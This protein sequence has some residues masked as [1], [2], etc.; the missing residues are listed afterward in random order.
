MFSE[1]GVKVALT[2]YVVARPAASIEY[3]YVVKKQG[4]LPER[5]QISAT[6]PETRIALLK[7]APLVTKKKTPTKTKKKKP[8]KTEKK[9]K[10]T[11]IFAR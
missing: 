11:P 2:P 4:Y 7:K 6:S 3:I 8:A 10:K 1:S 9:T 5:V